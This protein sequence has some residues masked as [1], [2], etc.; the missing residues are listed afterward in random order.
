MINIESDIFE[1]LT[2]FSKGAIEPYTESRSFKLD[3]STTIY[4]HREWVR[5]GCD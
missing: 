3:Y 4:E 2:R 5:P 1:Q